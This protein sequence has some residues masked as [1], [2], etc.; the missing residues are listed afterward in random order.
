MMNQ[1]IFEINNARWRC[2][3]LELMR[4]VVGHVTCLYDMSRSVDDA[5]SPQNQNN[6]V[7]N[8]KI[9]EKILTHWFIF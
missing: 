6:S 7:E 4:F 3:P 9:S 1:L 5:T 8:L 2:T